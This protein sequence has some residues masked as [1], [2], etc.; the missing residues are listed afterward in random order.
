MIS[1]RFCTIQS[2][3][4]SVC[5]SKNMKTYQFNLILL[6]F[7][8]YSATYS[9]VKTGPS[10]TKL[11]WLLGQWKRTNVKPGQTGLETW[12]KTSSVAFEGFGITIKGADTVF[13]EKLK[14]IVKD[15]TVF[16]VADVAENKE[17]TYFK[18]T[19]ITDEGFICENTEHDFPKKITYR[20]SG[21]IL[22]ATISGNGKSFDFDLVKIK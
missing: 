14:I 5:L 7:I 2:A 13:S 20:R 6:L 3:H 11:N 15:N 21:K 1:C 18:L 10:L 22:K 17:P 4:T 8:C 9:Q 19:E 12:K 16:Y